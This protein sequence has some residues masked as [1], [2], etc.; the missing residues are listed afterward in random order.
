LLAELIESHNY[1][2]REIGGSSH[3]SVESEQSHMSL[4]RDFLL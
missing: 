3:M 1:V 2:A 4:V